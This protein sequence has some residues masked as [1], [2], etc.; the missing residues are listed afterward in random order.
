M[1]SQAFLVC[2]SLIYI[3][4]IVEKIL[5]NFCVDPHVHMPYGPADKT[6]K[7]QVDDI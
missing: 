6:S 7:L 3:Q 4:N 2:I 1:V 5:V